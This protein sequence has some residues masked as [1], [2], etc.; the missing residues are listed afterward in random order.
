AITPGH[1]LHREQVLEILWPEVEPESALNSFGKALHA[2]RR[3]LEPELLPRESSSY[4]RLTDSIVA[5]DVEHVWI[6]L[7]HFEQLAESALCQRDT[8]AYEAAI[9]AYGGDLLPEDRYED[10]CAERR[11]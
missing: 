8:R 3:A 6:D 9:E 11:E 5:L 7:D 4:L 1:Q 10:W 2:A